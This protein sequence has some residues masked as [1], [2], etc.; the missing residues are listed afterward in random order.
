MVLPAKTAVFESV[1]GV[2]AP[3]GTAAPPRQRAAAPLSP[4]GG[5]T[6]KSGE[7]QLIE[8]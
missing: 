6:L 1:V 2:G 5:E 8:L 4:P 3:K 7:A